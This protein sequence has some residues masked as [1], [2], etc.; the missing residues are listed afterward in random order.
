[1]MKYM[2]FVE[3]GQGQSEI[4][5]CATMRVGAMQIVPFR[6]LSFH[7]QAM[8]VHD[9]PAPATVSFILWIKCSCDPPCQGVCQLFL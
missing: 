6:D 9:K 4:P 3:K 8:H 7:N 2:L 1:M 5:T